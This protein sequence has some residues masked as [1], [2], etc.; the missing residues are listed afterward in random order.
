[1]QVQTM[2]LT[3]DDV[4]WLVIAVLVV[5]VALLLFSTRKYTQLAHIDAVREGLSEAIADLRVRIDER[6]SE[7]HALRRNHEV[8]KQQVAALRDEV[9][10]TYEVTRRIEDYLLQQQGKL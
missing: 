9:L 2:V 8:L 6:D 5:A 7:I 1:M 4:Q 3:G 10:R